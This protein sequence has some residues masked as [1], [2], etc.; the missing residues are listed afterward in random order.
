MKM[1]IQHNLLLLA[2][3]VILANSFTC[4]AED[5]R[6]NYGLKFDAG[7]GFYVTING[8]PN[9]LTWTKKTTSL[10]N[11]SDIIKIPPDAQ[12]YSYGLDFSTGGM[13]G[14]QPPQF[15]GYGLSYMETNGTFQGM[16]AARFVPV[17]GYDQKVYRILFDGPYDDLKSDKLQY[18][19]WAFDVPGSSQGFLFHFVNAKPSK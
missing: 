17:A 8:I 19:F 1:K 9:P 6:K 7:I 18:N 16:W 2:V 14:P 4:K 5:Y 12:F 11:E 10:A 3:A 13:A 15:L